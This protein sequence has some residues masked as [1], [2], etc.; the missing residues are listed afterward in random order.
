MLKEFRYQGIKL[1]NKALVK[2]SVYSHNKNGAKNQIQ[3]LSKQHKF[4]IVKIE[5]KKTFL[6]SALNS[7][8][9][10]ING[11]IESFTKEEVRNVLENLKYSKIKIQPKLFDFHFKPPFQEIVMFISMTSDMLKE[12]MK[13]DDILKILSNDIK[14]KTFKTTIKNISRELRQGKDGESVFNKYS[15]IFG[16]FTSYMLGLASKSGNMSEIYKSISLHLQRQAQFKKDMKSAIFMPM[17]TVGFMALAFGYYF[18]KLFPQTTVMFTQFGIELPPLTKFT[19]GAVTFMKQYWYAFIITGIAPI[20]YFAVKWSSEKGKIARDKLL[21]KLPVIGILMHRMAIQVF[22]KVFSIIYTGSGNN[23]EIIQIAAEACGNKYMETRIKNITIPMMLKSGKGLVD[24]LEES[25]VFNDT[26][27]S[28]LNAGA[29]SG[30]I[31]NAATQIAN[32]YEKDTEYRLKSI[33]NLMD[34]LT[35]AFIFI[36]MIFLI[37]ISAESAMVRPKSPGM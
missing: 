32:Y 14:N 34:L 17:V 19:M 7:T 35:A 23:I 27:I 21:I 2:G 12:N 30:S 16:K 8:G 29:A 36:S 24:A 10:K 33:I 6:Y 31:K 3:S 18:F 26:V 28:R 15:D 1:D 11:E 9:K 4:N 25:A 20:I 22:F 5:P 37:L 13:Y